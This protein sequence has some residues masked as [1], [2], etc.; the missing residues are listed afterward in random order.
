MP[1]RNLYRLAGWSAI[2]FIALA[3]AMYAF[4]GWMFVTLSILGA[5]C[6]GVIFYTLFEFFRSQNARLALIMFVC[7]I[8][9]LILENIGFM[10]ESGSETI[11]AIR[12]LLLGTA[13][14]LFGYLGYGNAQTPR[15]LAICAYVVGVAG[16]AAGAAGLIGQTS[17]GEIASYVMFIPFIVW[18][19]GIWRWFLKVDAA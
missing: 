16:L 19:I 7:T 3:F 1:N 15:W 8:V 5:L 13:F 17:L 4:T 9:A 10:L 14:L 2:V 11:L 12:F 6:L 18:L